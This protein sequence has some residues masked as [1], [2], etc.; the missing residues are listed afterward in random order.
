M[1]PGIKFKGEKKG[2]L[3]FKTHLYLQSICFICTFGHPVKLTEENKEDYQ[4]YSV[5]FPQ[6]WNLNPQPS[7]PQRKRNE[8]YVRCKSTASYYRKNENKPPLNS[9]VEST[10]S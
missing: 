6:S 2:Y 7:H 10:A 5:P 3:S 9:C 1:G 4:I 8:N